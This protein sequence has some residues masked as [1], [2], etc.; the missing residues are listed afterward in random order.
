MTDV[1]MSFL[2]HLEEFRKRF[3]VSLAAALAGFLVCYGFK[4]QI[5]T[6]MAHPLIK[7]MPDSGNLAMLNVSE[8]FFTYLKLAFFAGIFVASPVIIYE[9]WAFV[10][11]GLYNKERRAI[12]PFFILSV[13]LFIG[14]VLFGYFVVFP[15]GYKFLL[16]YATGQIVATLSIGWYISFAVKLLLAF[17]IIF[18]LPLLLFFLNRIGVVGVEALRKNRKFAFLGAF[19]V[20]A[21]LTPPDVITQAFMAAPLFLL[22]EMSI[23]M[24]AIFGKKKKEEEEPA[25]GGEKISRA[26][27]KDK[28]TSTGDTAEK[29]DHPEDRS[30]AG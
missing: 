14:G 11:P 25:E 28:D 6:I 22:Y 8:G 19:L 17:G 30:P 7:V 3:I 24:I 26:G 1:R 4:E 15:Y 20:G 12:V 9:I 23:W 18:Q 27:D 5:F 16:N 21:V 2:K 13:I 29:T 10:S